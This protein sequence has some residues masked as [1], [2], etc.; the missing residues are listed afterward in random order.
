MK[1][2]GLS[3]ILAS[4]LVLSACA[5]G[6]TAPAQAPTGGAAPTAGTDAAGTDTVDAGQDQNRHLVVLAPAFPISMDTTL[7]N[8]F[9]SSLVNRQFA[10]TLVIFDGPDFNVIP[11]L[12]ESWHMP[13][14]ETL[15][16]NLRQ[17]VLFHNGDEMRASDVKFSI[18]RALDSPPVRVIFEA[19]RDVDVIDDFTVQ[20]NMNFPFA[21]ILGHLTHLGSAVI[22]E[23][24]V[25]EA[26]DEY[27][28]HPIG[29]G[30]F[31][32]DSMSL[33]DQ[34]NLVRFEDYW[35]DAPQI[36]SLAIRVVPEA[37]NRLIEI[38]TGAGHIAFDISP[39]NIPRMQ[40]D[41]N[42]AYDRA[43]NIR[44]H[45]VGFNTQYGPLQ[46][47]RVRQAINYALNVD[48]IVDNVFV[49]LG[50]PVHGPLVGIDGAASPEPFEFNLDRARELLAE[51]GYADGFSLE[52]WSNVASQQ[53]TD[54]GI[55]IQNMLAQVDIDVSLVTLEFATFMEGINNGQHG[56]YATGWTNV[57]ADP[58]YGLTPLFHSS[59]FGGAGNRMF[60]SNPEV[61]RLLDLGRQELDW[62]VRYEIYQEVQHILRDE[63]PA[64]FI[65]QSEELV[66]ISPDLNGFVNF[67]I[68]TPRFKTVFF[69]N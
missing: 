46:D 3:I 39:H 34:V 24:A 23:R 52:L 38:E 31:M 40:E 35:G 64:V 62:N 21:P 65:W 69:G 42:L 60:F 58:D 1:K 43:G 8:D 5:G 68:R 27:V 44:V 16:M 15:V 10:E 36:D 33:G 54:I 11:H 22:S 30:P 53:D 41:P 6:G 28:N 14:A 19:I 2:T 37:A 18:E 59:N 45:F 20:I 12:A 32:F 47:M 26:G 17:G 63:A 57:S 50:W 13:D 9:N 55:I 66:G 7:A 61:D 51:A 29:T 48:A 4:V 25:L 49:G 67:P 56:M